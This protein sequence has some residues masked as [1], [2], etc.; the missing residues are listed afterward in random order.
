MNMVDGA[1]SNLALR[2]RATHSSH[3][4]PE[5]TENEGKRDRNLLFFEF[6]EI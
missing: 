4:M 3:S 6:F 5:F 1:L 2:K